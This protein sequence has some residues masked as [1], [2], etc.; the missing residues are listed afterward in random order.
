MLT[1]THWLIH[2][3]TPSLLEHLVTL[4]T[5][6]MHGAFHCNLGFKTRHMQ[7][8]KYSQLWAKQQRDI[9]GWA[10]LK[11]EHSLVRKFPPIHLMGKPTKALSVFFSQLPLFFSW[12][13]YSLMELESQDVWFWIYSA[14][15]AERAGRPMWVMRGAGGVTLISSGKDTWSPTNYEINWSLEFNRSL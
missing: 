10:V 13:F 12:Q 5:R 1:L 7:M 4:N 15:S 14:E 2:W 11:A 3:L 6:I 8:M 9:F